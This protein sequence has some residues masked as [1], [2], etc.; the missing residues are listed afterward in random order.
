M[1]QASTQSRNDA[2]NA[3][4]HESRLILAAMLEQVTADN[5]HEAIETG[6]PMGNEIW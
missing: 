3:D 6:G 5:V 2:H 1:D 4:E